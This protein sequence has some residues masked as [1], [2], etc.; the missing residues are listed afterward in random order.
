[1]TFRSIVFFIMDLNLINKEVFS[2][3]KNKFPDNYP[4]R[5]MLTCC[6]HY[7]LRTSSNDNIPF[8]IA[9]FSSMK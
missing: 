2:F 9:T 8:L 7:G 5:P 4:Y 6:D 1:M 3:F